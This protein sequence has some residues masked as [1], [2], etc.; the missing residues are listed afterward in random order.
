M[1]GTKQ[2][3]KT[4]Y[5]IEQP[6]RSLPHFRLMANGT[7]ANCPFKTITM[8]PQQGGQLG[9]IE[10]ACGTQCPLAQITEDEEG[11]MNYVTYCGGNT[12]VREVTEKAEELIHKIP[13]IVRP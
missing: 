3:L 1:E 4:I 13:S 5:E 11:K 9:A 2:K 10:H 12:I 6:N 8:I 7:Q